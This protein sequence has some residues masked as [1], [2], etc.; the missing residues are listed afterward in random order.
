LVLINN[1]LLAPDTLN[2]IWA[3]LRLRLLII[4][5]WIS[6]THKADIISGVALL[7]A[8]KDCGQ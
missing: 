8:I 1:S 6:S 4:V 5:Y 7:G 2:E 3:N